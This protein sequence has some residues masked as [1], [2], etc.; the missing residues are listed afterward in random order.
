[1]QYT[2]ANIREILGCESHLSHPEA[3]IAGIVYDTRRV[4]QGE[5]ALFVALQGASRK[6]DAFVKDAY[7]KGIRSFLVSEL[8]QGYA[9]FAD[10]NWFIVPNTLLALQQ[11]AAKHRR[12][13]TGP[14]VAITGSNGKTI[15]K[16]W[17]FHL[18]K[19][20]FSIARSPR[21]YNSG[22]G[23]AIS[24]LGIEPWHSMAL[25][26][27]GISQQGEMAAL[28]GMTQASL[29]IFTHL[30]SAH[31]AG[32]TSKTEKV[33]EKFILFRNCDVLVYPYDIAEVRA[34]VGKLRAQNPLL[35]TYS[36]DLRRG[37]LIGLK[38][39]FLA[40]RVVRFSFDTGQPC[41]N[42]KFHFQ[43]KQ[44]LKMP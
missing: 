17:L 43:T 1:M 4:Y 30:G 25:I 22:L 13:F 2:A 10:A 19:Y 41:M 35:K 24:L 28:E 14:V 15:V 36:W 42:L 7:S 3:E 37:Q 8:P 12:S 34:E 20:D 39:Y 21:S 31:D 26:E 38:R 44:V 27:A 32:F 23:V 33:A 16:E 29:G 18:L 5:R 11:L 6:G 9:L 40:S